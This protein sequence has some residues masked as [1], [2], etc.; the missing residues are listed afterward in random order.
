MASCLFFSSIEDFIIFLDN[1]R[2]LSAT[3][4]RNTQLIVFLNLCWAG[5]DFNKVYIAFS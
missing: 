4:I 5:T 1:S 2:T 3:K